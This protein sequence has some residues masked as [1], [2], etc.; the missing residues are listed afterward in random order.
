MRIIIPGIRATREIGY[1]AQCWVISQ[2]IYDADTAAL[3]TN[4]ALDRGFGAAYQCSSYR[5]LEYWYET[6]ISL[7]TSTTPTTTDPPS[8][9]N[10]QLNITIQGQGTTSYGTGTI[11]I[12]DNQRV[13]ITAIP[14]TGW[15]FRSW[16]WPGN[17]YNYAG[18]TENPASWTM[19][20]DMNI[21]AIFDQ[22]YSS[23][24]VSPPNPVSNPVVPNDTSTA[25]GS[26]TQGGTNPA[27]GAIIA[28]P[29]KSSSEPKVTAV[30]VTAITGSSANISWTTD[31]LTIGQI[32]Y[33][34]DTPALSQIEKTLSLDHIVNITDLKPCTKYSFN[35]MS[36]DQNKKLTKSDSYTF[37]TNGVMAEFDI[38]EVK[39]YPREIKPGKN[40]IIVV[41]VKNSSE[42]TGTC[43]LT[44]IIQGP[45]IITIGT[46]SFEV[47]PGENKSVE[48]SVVFTQNGIYKI[49]VNDVS[50]T[51]KVTD[52]PSKTYYVTNYD[53][54]NEFYTKL[55]DSE[56]PDFDTRN[57]SLFFQIITAISNQM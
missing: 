40:T 19:A 20:N 25:S 13:S 48:F 7:L 5:T 56:S 39:T 32:E 34:V 43:E 21:I 14:A 28:P 31:E 27:S 8:T 3:Y 51:Q 16:S 6:Y 11:N 46:R 9:S 45:E 24:Q 29:I 23:N 57:Y 37:T 33:S 41:T 38:T 42:S 12:P 2:D 26:G 49:T 52:M 50:I 47:G 53:Y 55:T 30:E 36:Y 4:E 10:N 35:I 22:V 1:E 54:L 15:I 17:D 18:W 44:P